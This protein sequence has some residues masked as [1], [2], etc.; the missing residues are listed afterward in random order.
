LS[1]YS[2]WFTYYLK[3]PF[4]YIR[5]EIFF[6]SNIEN[7]DPMRQMKAELSTTAPPLS[8]IPLSKYSKIQTFITEL[9]K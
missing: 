5:L 6:Q 3:I 9:D 1:D 2:R 7:H 4:D 8:I